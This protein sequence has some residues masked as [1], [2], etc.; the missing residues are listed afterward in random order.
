[1]LAWQGDSEGAVVRHRG[2]Q[3]LLHTPVHTEQ[4]RVHSLI[5]NSACC[6]RTAAPTH[7]AG[8][9]WASSHKIIKTCPKGEF[10]GR[11]RTIAA[12]NRCLGTLIKS[13]ASPMIPAEIWVGADLGQ[14]EASAV[15]TV[16]ST[17]SFDLPTTKS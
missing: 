14:G 1:M 3:V 13:S 12:Q 10:D 17:C 8:S 2:C 9:A 15:L 7:P 6:S 16:A 4:W 11:A 5:P